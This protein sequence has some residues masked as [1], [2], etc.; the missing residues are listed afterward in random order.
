[1]AKGAFVQRDDAF[2]EE[3][4]AKHCC[5]KLFSSRLLKFETNSNKI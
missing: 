1:V 5:M 4:T 3:E 2:P